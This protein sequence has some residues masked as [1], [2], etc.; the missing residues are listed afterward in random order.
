MNG[1]LGNLGA[2]RSPPRDW[3]IMEWMPLGE[4]RQVVR[5]QSRSA[6]GVRA[7][8][9]DS[10]WV[11]S[12]SR[13][14]GEL[15]AS[16]PPGAVDRFQHLHESRAAVA[17]LLREIGAAP[18][19]LGVRRQEHGERPAALLAGGAQ[20]GHVDLVDVRPLLAIDLD[21]DVEP[22]HHLGDLVVFE[23]LMRHDVAPV[24]GGVAD[25]EQDR[26]V[27]LACF[28]ERSGS[29]RA[30]SEP[31]CPCAGG[32]RGWSLPTSR[33]ACG[34]GTRGSHP[35][36]GPEVRA[37]GRPAQ[38]QFPDTIFALSSGKP[39]SGV[40]VMRVS[41][42]GSREIVRGGG[43]RRACCSPGGS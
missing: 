35:V 33:F 27:E 21:V 36:I 19:R 14:G 4:G 29:T 18:E 42:P 28:G 30:A 41:G 5:A 15:V 25:G 31:D 23:A 22:V 16:V 32:D 13:A 26:P 6:A 1:A 34:S 38:M 8:S 12:V 24:A 43:R 7:D 39:P 20:C 3:S 10:T 9:L 2:P 17:R 37:I 11:F 40:A